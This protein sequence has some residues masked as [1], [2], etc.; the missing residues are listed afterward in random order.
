MIQGRF[1]SASTGDLHI[2]KGTMNSQKYHEMLEK[3]QHG[4]TLC[5]NKTTSVTTHCV[6]RPS[7][8]TCT[9]SL[10]SSGVASFPTLIQQRILEKVEGLKPERSILQI[11]KIQS[12]YASKNGEKSQMM[13]EKMSS[14]YKSSLEAVLANKG[15]ATILRIIFMYRYQYLFTL[16]LYA[17]IS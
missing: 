16:F 1:S 4:K 13:Y 6:I 12:E 11:L 8:S 7:G 10:F 5:F 9:V 14:S 15:H 17:D 2:V 3:T